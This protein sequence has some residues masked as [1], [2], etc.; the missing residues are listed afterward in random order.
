[1]ARLDLIPA[2]PVTPRELHIV[3]KDERIHTSNEIEVPF[4]RNVARLDDGDT[5]AWHS[6]SKIAWSLE[7]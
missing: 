6:G 5:L 3:Q 2:P 4:P 7:S 1:V